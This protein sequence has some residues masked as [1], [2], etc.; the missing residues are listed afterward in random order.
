MKTLKNIENSLPPPALPGSGSMGLISARMLGHPLI[1]ATK[2]K[3]K[4]I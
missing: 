1:D 3:K 2:V 4:R